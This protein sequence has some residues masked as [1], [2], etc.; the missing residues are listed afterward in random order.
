MATA[1]FLVFIS[2]FILPYQNT[3]TWLYNIHYWLW[4]HNKPICTSHA[5]LLFH[6][7]SSLLSAKTR[8]PNLTHT[9]MHSPSYPPL[10]QP[11]LFHQHMPRLIHRPPLHISI[12]VIRFIKHRKRWITYRSNHVPFRCK[13]V[14]RGSGGLFSGV[15]V[16][17]SISPVQC[18]LIKSLHGRSCSAAPGSSLC[19]GM[20]SRRT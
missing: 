7:F 4:F 10:P 15:I 11:F 12:P 8:N 13:I 9:P 3:L 20:Y 16:S 6:L 1:A 2:F 5:P 18:P 17:T 19:S 14:Y